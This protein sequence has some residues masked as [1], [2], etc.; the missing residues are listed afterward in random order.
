MC[1]LKLHNLSSHDIS[2][3]AVIQKD[4]HDQGDLVD[5]VLL[6]QETLE[7]RMNQTGSAATVGRDNGSGDAYPR[8]ATGLKP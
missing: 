1:L 2:I 6:T 4:G 5:I 3:D 7:A 8:S